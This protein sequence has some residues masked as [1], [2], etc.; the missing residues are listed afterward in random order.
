MAVRSGYGKLT[1]RIEHSAIEYWRSV[2]E[3]AGETPRSCGE[4]LDAIDCPRG[5]TEGQ[6][7]DLRRF[8][9]AL[10]SICRIAGNPSLSW[11]AGLTA[12]ENIGG[13]VSP[14]IWGSRTLGEALQ[15][16]SSVYPTLQDSSLV[17]LCVDAGEA[18]LNY[19]ILDPDIW[20]RHEDAM[21]SLGLYARLLRAAAPGA[22][23]E[24]SV[25]VEVE[26]NFVGAEIGNFVKTRVNYG[27]S[28]NALVFPAALL[29]LPL[30]TPKPLPNAKCAGAIFR[31]RDNRALTSDRVRELIFSEY[32]VFPL[33]EKE[34]ARRLLMSER[35]L[36]RYLSEEGMAFREI[37]EDCRM[38]QARLELKRLRSESLAQIG[39]R[40]GYSDQGNFT[41]AFVRWSGVAPGRFRALE[42][43]RN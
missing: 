20:P 40:V 13:E 35:S 32:D 17:R 37:I 15:R 8:V 14:F 12:G 22:W 1:A 29:D 28:A 5:T 34:V 19:K 23:R 26:R 6:A 24:I 11:T 7:A 38:R 3:T 9:A 31:G 33:S 18:S 43:V 21:F 16:L 4:L 36:R 25:N 39:M 10:E 27:Q 41:R 2:V 30:C 42:D